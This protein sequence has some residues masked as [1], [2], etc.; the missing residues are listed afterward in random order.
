MSSFYKHR[1]AQFALCKAV[2]G[3]L[4]AVSEEDGDEVTRAQVVEIISEDKVKVRLFRYNYP[5]KWFCVFV[6]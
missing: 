3:Q 6:N 2:V 1:F 4:V 5:T